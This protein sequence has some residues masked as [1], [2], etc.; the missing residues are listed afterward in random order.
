MK[1]KKPNRLFI[2]WKKYQRRPEVLAPLLDAK[3]KFIPHLFKIKFLRPFDYALKLIVSI[4]EIIQYKPDFVI[5]QCPPTFSVLPALIARVPY[6]IDAH[7]P[8]LQVKMWRNLPFTKYLIENAA[9]VIVHNP[10]I[11][12]LAKSIYPS[13]LFLQISDPVSYIASTREHK[14]KDKQILVIS[15]FDPW[16]EPIELLVETIEALPEYSF[17]I[18]AEIDKLPSNLSRRLQQL[19]NL[20]LT[21]FLPTSE[22]HQL[23]CSSMATLVLTTS[24]ATQPSGACEALSSDTPLIVS[25]TS[26]TQKLYGEWAM[27]VEN[28]PVSIVK[29]I[30]SL[31]LQELNLSAYRDRWNKQVQQEITKLV[32]LIDRHN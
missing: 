10:E 16:D 4:K 2:V 31:S 25:K 32:E 7:N 6:I 20:V 27:L 24:E 28:S 3:V 22:Y 29:A 14:R 15:S 1:A 21:G 17:I 8:L 5:A 23:L 11:L 9:A 13:V 12:Q 30:R 19:N 18:T 26:L